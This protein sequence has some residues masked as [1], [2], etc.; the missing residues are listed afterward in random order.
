MRPSAWAGLAC[1][2]VRDEEGKVMKT[3]MRTDHLLW[4]FG[5]IVALALGCAVAKRSVPE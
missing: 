4:M 2:S 1:P 3:K 5:A